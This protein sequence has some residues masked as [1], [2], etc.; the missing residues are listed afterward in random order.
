[1]KYW[2]EIIAVVAI[3]I[4]VAIFLI[5]NANIQ[6]TI[7]PGEEAWGGADTGASEIIKAT[8]YEPWFSPVWEPPGS[9]IETL[10]FS[11]QAALG[12][13]VIGYFFG[14]Y[15]GKRDAENSQ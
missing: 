14:Y 3:T 4:F 5:Q 10:I 11:L 2:L 15:R 9:E 12:A 6:S 7:R 1:M 8:G 13:T